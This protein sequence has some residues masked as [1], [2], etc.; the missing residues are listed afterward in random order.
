MQYLQLYSYDELYRLSIAQPELFWQATLK[1]LGLRFIEPYRQAIDTSR[2]IQWPEFFVEGKLNLADNAVGRHLPQRSGETAL[3]WEGEDRAVREI[4]FG[5]LEALTA[6]A[7]NAFKALD[8]RKGDRVGL[9]LPMLPETASGALALARIGAIFVP[10]FSGYGAEAAAARLNDAEAKLVLT[11]DGFYRR[12]SR[13]KLLEAARAAAQLSPSVKQLLVVRR[14]GDAALAANETAWDALVPGQST[15]CPYQAMGSMEPF[16][17]IYTSGTTGKPKGTVHY[18]AGFP[19]K[20]AQDIAHLFDLRQ[21]QRLFWF[22]DMGWM[23]GPWAILGGLSVGGTV[24][25]YEG[26][27]DYPGPDRLWGLVERHRITHLGLSPT[28]VRALLPF[29][30]G[31][32][33]AHDLSSLRILGSTG[34]PWN[35]E[36]YRWFSQVVGGG[37]CP[38]LNYSGGTEIGGGILGCTLFRDIQVMGFNTAV[39]GVQAAVLNPQ[40]QSVQ[41]QV[42]ELAV[43]NAWPG[44][45][46]GFW[47]APERY[48]STYWNRFEGKWVHGDWA[49]VDSAGH[50]T[51]QG[52]SDDTLKIAGKR[53]GP[54]ELESAAVEHLAVKEAAAIGVPHE[55]KGETAVVF[56]VLRTG[57]NPSPTLAQAIS[58]VVAQKLGKALRPDHIVF[59]P[60]L[61]KTRNAKVM[62]RVIRAAYLGQEAGDL[63]ALENPQAVEAIRR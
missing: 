30:D 47:Q 57:E 14:F 7:A 38:I 25:L 23:M 63:S 29:G 12:G 51:L 20:A 24:V 60:D 26:A 28:L 19:I 62:R 42:G 49:M 53:V 61:P 18:H 22:T 13:V 41:N 34:E 59:V 54:A 1:L 43:L 2:G 17:L 10:I 27:P 32:V 46:K 45:T 40:G 58:D 3:V 44:M 35:E 52:R 21:G 56:V 6:Q 36:P 37:R 50:W 11:A 31:P 55:V 15:K 4:T 8:I 33:K 39:P 5:E 16:M 48:L 9:F